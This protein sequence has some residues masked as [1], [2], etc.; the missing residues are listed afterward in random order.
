MSSRYPHIN[1][2]KIDYEAQFPTNSML[3]DE[4]KKIK[5]IKKVHKNN[6]SQLGLTH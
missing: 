2:I 6:S 5:L 4:I 3:N 1:Q